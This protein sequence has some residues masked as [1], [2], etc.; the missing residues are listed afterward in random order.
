MLIA[1]GHGGTNLGGKC[2]RASS[3][4]L[5]CPLSKVFNPQTVPVEL[6]KH[7]TSGRGRLGQFS[8][9]ESARISYS[10]N[11][12]SCPQWYLTGFDFDFQPQQRPS[13]CRCCC[14]EYEYFILYWIFQL[15]GRNLDA[16]NLQ[17][18][19]QYMEKVPVVEAVRH[20]H[21]YQTCCCCYLYLLGFWKGFILNL[22]QEWNTAHTAEPAEARWFVIL[23]CINKSYSTC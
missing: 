10:W 9:C 21:L 18:D 3:P 19:S 22:D 5:R 23:G 8:S 6:F 20:T 17:K 14:K 12:E 2:E 4:P 16:K 15:W 7:V 1:P 13:K 11:R